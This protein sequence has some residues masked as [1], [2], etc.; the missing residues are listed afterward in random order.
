MLFLDNVY[1]GNVTIWKL[2][3]EIVK[4]VYEKEADNIY[5]MHLDSDCDGYS[6]LTEHIRL[7]MQE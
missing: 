3:L 4:D 2:K 5:I 1:N 6:L 7:S